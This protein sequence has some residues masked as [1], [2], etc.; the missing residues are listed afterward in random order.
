[1]QG[2]ENPHRLSLMRVAPD[3]PAALSG[4]HG[5]VDTIVSNG[6][7]GGRVGRVHDVTDE[8]FVFV[9][10]VLAND[11]LHVGERSIATSLRQLIAGL[12][13]DVELEGHSRGKLLVQVGS[14][15]FGFA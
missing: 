2:N 6:D 15:L 12:I 5:D 1:M 9:H 14:E 13:R 10:R 11:E 7:E 4:I 3:D 8:E